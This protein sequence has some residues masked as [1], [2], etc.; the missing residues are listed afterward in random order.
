MMK[1]NK[2]TDALLVVDV[3]NDFCPGGSLAVPNGDHVIV[4]LNS[5]CPK[6]EFIYATRDWHTPDHCSF[7]PQGGIWPP[8]CIAGT[9]GAA[10]P[11]ALNLHNYMGEHALIISKAFTQD[12]DTYSGFGNPILGECFVT[13]GI[14]RLFVGGLATDYCVKAT[15]LDAV[16][17]G[18]QVVVVLD[19]I[20]G[21]NVNPGDAD[22]AIEEMV[23]A[24]AQT[25]YS[26]EVT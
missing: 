11:P 17:A 20:M 3:Q 21:V 12:K 14:K 5:L 24:G 10:F 22:K 13:D 4:P 23:A 18:L 1:V 15:V 2:T 19:G 25:C 6:F 9:V 8:H 16:K 7:V 26:T